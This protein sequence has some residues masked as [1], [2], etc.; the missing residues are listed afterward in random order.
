MGIPRGGKRGSQIRLRSTYLDLRLIDV[1]GQA[2]DDDLAVSGQGCS[3]GSGDGG[4]S[5]SCCGGL[6][7]LLHAADWGSDGGLG[8][9]SG[10]AAGAAL[11]TS[12]AATRGLAA[13]LHDLIE[14]LV[15]LS[16][17]V[18]GFGDDDVFWLWWLSGH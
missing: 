6:G 7:I 5:R 15:E 13:V 9:F 2:A 3:L 1:L 18:D 10:G 17:H 8:L 16:R 4:S 14:R 12:A 11:L